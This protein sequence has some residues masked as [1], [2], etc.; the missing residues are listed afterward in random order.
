MIEPAA[1]PEAD[2]LNAL[3]AYGRWL[4]RHDRTEEAERVI[5]QCTALAASHIGHPWMPDQSEMLRAELLERR[6]DPDGARE[7]REGLQARQLATTNRAESVLVGPLLQRGFQAVMSGRLDEAAALA[8]EALALSEQA[9]DWDHA[10]VQYASLAAQIG[11]QG[12]GAAADRLYQRGYPV[13]RRYAETHMSGFLAFLHDY[14]HYLYNRKRWED[15]RSVIEERRELIA[16]TKGPDSAQMEEIYLA[17]IDLV[18]LQGRRHE[19]LP[20]AAELLAHQERVHGKISEPSLRA[21]ETVAE[22]HSSRGEPAEA[23]EYRRR[24]LATG[25]SLY[26]P[27]DLRRARILA[28]L[29]DA[30]MQ[31]ERADEAIAHIE[32]AIAIAGRHGSAEA[33]TFRQQLD[34]IRQRRASPPGFSP[35]GSR[36]FE[37][38]RFSRTGGTR[39]REPVR[40]QR[41]PQ[42]K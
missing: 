12:D 11:N 42:P 26:P 40:V 28:V 21:L 31:V 35:D 41:S 37:T 3:A 15:A 22:I 23:L 25:E 34:H 14:T 1:Q 4:I 27:P 39:L 33:A 29:A 10:A 38:D 30:E 18:S 9:V 13:V 17:R 6:G 5:D 19:S 8:E 20:D 32:Q 36:W 7:I 2:R 16:A 24:A